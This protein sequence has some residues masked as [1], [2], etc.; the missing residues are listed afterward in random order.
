M[1]TTSTML[2]VRPERLRPGWDRDRIMAEI[3][4]RG[5][6]CFTGSCSEIYL[7]KAFE[8][9]GLRPPSGCRWRASWA[10]PA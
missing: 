6:P 9:P 3:A 2:F 10:R 4:R 1:P 5:V 8:A 7:E